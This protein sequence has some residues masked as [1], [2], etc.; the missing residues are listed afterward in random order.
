MADE[1]AEENLIDGK[2]YKLVFMTKVLT[3]KIKEPENINYWIVEPNYIRIYRVLIK[4]V[5]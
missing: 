3:E 1:K 2:K 4:E 5:L